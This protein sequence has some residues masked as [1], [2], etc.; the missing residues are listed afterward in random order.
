M[1]HPVQGKLDR[2]WL[3]RKLGR[4]SSKNTHSKF[5][6]R[7]RTNNTPSTSSRNLTGVDGNPTRQAQVPSRELDWG[8]IGSNTP[9]ASPTRNIEL[10]WG[11]LIVSSIQTTLNEFWHTSRVGSA[12]SCPDLSGQCCPYCSPEPFPARSGQRKRQ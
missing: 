3:M 12:F 2:G 8:R 9:S 10:N 1:N 5:G 7:R 4:I 11:R 6:A